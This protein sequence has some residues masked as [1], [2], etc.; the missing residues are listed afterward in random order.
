M[1]KYII[2]KRPEP[3]EYDAAEAGEWEEFDDAGLFVTLGSAWD[4]IDSLT[5]FPHIHYDYRVM[6]QP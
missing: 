6:Q 1:P 5:G 2:E 4:Y 3:S